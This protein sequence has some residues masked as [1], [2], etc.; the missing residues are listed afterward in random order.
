MGT[1]VELYVALRIQRQKL[2]ES[3]VTQPWTTSLA[4]VLLDVVI[5]CMIY[6]KRQRTDFSLLE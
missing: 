2:L 5:L 1:D 3:W 6:G 4:A